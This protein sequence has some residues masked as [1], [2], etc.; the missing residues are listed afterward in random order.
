MRIVIVGGGAAG[1]FAALLLARANHEVVVL[2]Q[3]HLEPTPDVE[4]AAA[5]A[6]RWTAPQIVQPHIVMARCRQLLRSRLPDVYDALLAAGVA[7]APLWTQMPPTLADTSARPSDDELTMLMSRR[8]TVDWVLKRAVLDQP[9]ITV[10]YGVQVTGLMASPEDPPRVTG[11]R[12]KQ[13]E[14]DADLIIDATGRRTRI[15]HWLGDIG[16]QPSATWFAECG[17]AY[18][19]RHY[20]LRP[21]ATLPGLPTTRIVAALDEFVVGIWG[22]DNRTMQL[23]V[24]PLAEDHRFRTLKRPEIFEAVLRTVPIYAAWLETLD[25]ITKVFPMAGL[26]NTMRRLIVDGAP[27]VTGLQALGDSVCTTNPTLGRG[28]S[29]ALAGAADLVD[30]LDRYADDFTALA[31]A[32]DGLAVEHV[33]PFYEE[34]AVIDKA[35]L[36]KVRHTIFDTP[37]LPPPPKDSGRVTYA[38]LRVAAQFDP[39]AFRA[40]WKTMGMVSRPNDIYTD[41]QVV[42]ATQAALQRYGSGLP[43]AQPTRAELL[44]ALGT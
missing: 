24:G 2:E 4:S 40:F 32:L 18:F 7:E 38:Q 37:A 23:G 44:V 14:H 35:L 16:A 27:V 34:Q 41:P 1:L 36:A 42:T 20:R 10:H 29:L 33:V 9:G 21:G 31:L 12:W 22:A 26:H 30:T 5:S 43:M 8:S 19:S 17:I 15:D 3:D 11:V 25:P 28:L 13:G 6:F 39:T